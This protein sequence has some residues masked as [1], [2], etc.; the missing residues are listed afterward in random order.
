[1]PTERFIRD[2]AAIC[3]DLERLARARRVITYGEAAALVGRSA[4]ALMPVLAAIRAEDARRGR[5][6]LTCL[7]VAEQE[8]C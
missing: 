5:P 3:D 8:G 1:M 4:A 2:K 6:D 7:V